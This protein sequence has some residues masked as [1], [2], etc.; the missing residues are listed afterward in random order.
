MQVL[1]TKRKSIPPQSIIAAL[2]SIC[3]LR[4][5]CYRYTRT[6]AKKRGS[7]HISVI[8]DQYSKVSR[9]ISVSGT[10]STHMGNI[11]LQ[12]WIVTFG[13][14]TYFLK[15]SG[16]QFVS[17]IF[18]LARRYLGVKHVTTMAYHLKANGEAKQFN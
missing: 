2:S 7:E 11:F 17:K 5:H 1:H 4:L 15:D 12:C 10:I 9:A 16:P 14:T 3:T 18:T 8:I 6:S 13:T